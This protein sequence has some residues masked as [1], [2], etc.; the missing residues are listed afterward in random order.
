M[1]AYTFADPVSGAPSFTGK[2]FRGLLGALAGGKASTRPIGARS[3]VSAGTP[4]SIVAASSTTWTVS[5]HS[6]MLDTSASAADGPTPYLFNTD[7]TG[8]MTAADGTNPR[9]DLL[10]IQLDDPSEG[11]GTSVP[12]PVVVYTVGT[13]AS[14]PAIPTTPARAF[15]IAQINVPHTGGGSPSITW[16]APYAVAAGG[17]VPASA[18]GQYPGSPLEG[19]YVDDAT[20]NALLRYDG[21]AWRTIVQDRLTY[22]PALT[23]AAGSPTIGNGT[24]LGWYQLVGRRCDF[25]IDLTW[26]STSNGGGGA[27][28][29]G[30]PVAA[31]ASA[32]NCEVS[33]LI[34]VSGGAIYQI[35]GQIAAS[36]T[37]MQFFAPGGPAIAS[38]AFMQNA[39][40]SFTA[41]T[42]VP[43]VSA[44]LTFAAGAGP[45][46]RVNGHY[47]T[48]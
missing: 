25:S 39:N 8:S 17:I 9:I 35:T 36:A 48:S 43:A 26:G 34:V 5:A 41:G 44:S 47:W 30:L 27:M 11:D 10:S 18:S 24:I 21:T 4:P 46:I 33:G 38:S 19:Q 14:S 28:S 6:G 15:A 7:Q 23:A 45:V 12:L 37:T 32:P 16:V 42:G 29:L 1:G 22:T 40:T 31:A 20:L 3:G 2:I 13:A